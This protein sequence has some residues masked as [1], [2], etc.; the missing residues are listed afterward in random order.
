MSE[1]IVTNDPRCPVQPGGSSDTLHCGSEAGDIMSV[2]GIVG[3]SW[4]ERMVLCGGS[5]GNDPAI[6]SPNFSVKEYSVL[7]PAVVTGS[8]W[9]PRIWNATTMQGSSQDTSVALQ[10]LL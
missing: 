7:L 1:N 2:A 4:E 8:W 5:K 10:K 6:F 3:T 9:R